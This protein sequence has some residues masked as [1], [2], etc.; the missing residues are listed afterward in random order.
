M[1]AM[2]GML[3]DITINPS[4]ILVA[5]SMSDIRIN[6]KVLVRSYSAMTRMTTPDPNAIP[7][8]INTA[9]A[10]RLPRGFRM[11]ALLPIQPCANGRLADLAVQARV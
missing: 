5:C 3:V 8:W 11:S 1:F 10:R 4:G 9:S 7:I 2:F 6:R